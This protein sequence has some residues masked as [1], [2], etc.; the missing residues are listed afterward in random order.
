MWRRIVWLVCLYK[1]TWRHIS[2]DNTF[3]ARRHEKLT[4]NNVSTEQWS[5]V[6]KQLLPWI[7][8]DYYATYSE[9]VYVAL[10]IQRAKRMRSVILSFL[11]C[12]A[13]PYFSTL[14]HKRYD[15]RKILFYIKCIVL[16]SLQLSY[17]TLLILRRMHIAIHVNYPLLLLDFNETWIFWTDFRQLLK[18]RI[19]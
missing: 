12:V 8:K 4:T 3:N 10:V 16:F 5:A 14:S 9:Y 19:L 13:V 11:A 18:Y 1:T 6:A 7:S 2:E 17:E 15:F